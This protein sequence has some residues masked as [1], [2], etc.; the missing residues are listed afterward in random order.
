MKLRIARHTNQLEIL[1]RF[2][3]SVLGLKVIGEFDGHDGYS[4]CFL[5]A[6]NVEWEIEFTENEED[7]S[8]QPDADDLLVFY[9]TRNQLED[10]KEKLQR[11]K[12]AIVLSKN[13]YWNLHG[14][15]F[16]DPDGFGIIIALENRAPLN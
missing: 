8:H 7:P 10:I 5:S 11:M 4:G 2:Y 16:K 15:E 14:I 9:V 6:E 1:K 3:T 12:V 13:P